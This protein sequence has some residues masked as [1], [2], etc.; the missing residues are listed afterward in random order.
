MCNIVKGLLISQA[1]GKLYDKITNETNVNNVEFYEETK[2]NWIVTCRAENREKLEF[3]LTDDQM[4]NDA[5]HAYLCDVINK[6]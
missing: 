3:K 1:T 5:H 4:L 2:G 6:G